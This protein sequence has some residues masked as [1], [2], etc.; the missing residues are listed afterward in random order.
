MAGYTFAMFLRFSTQLMV[1]EAFF[2]AGL[3]RRRWFPARL[4]AAL[5]TY[6]VAG[7]LLF[8]ALLNV[9]YRYWIVEIV[10]Y[11]VVFGATVALMCLLFRAPWRTVLFCATAAYAMQHI[12]YC[13]EHAIRSIWAWLFPSVAVP[14][15]LA[16]VLVMA[17][18]V[19]VGALMAATLMRDRGRRLQDGD[20]R[21]GLV[22]AAVLLVSV[23]LS[24]LLRHTSVADDMLLGV[25]CDLYAVVSCMLGFAMQ[26]GLW[27]RYR[28]ETDN[29]LLEQLLH[30]EYRLHTMSKRAIDAINMKS[31]DLKYR[32]NALR[33]QGAGGESLRHELDSL[34]SAV[35][36]Y[37]SVVSTGYDA[38]DLIVSEKTMICQHQG[39]AFTCV[40]DGA[41]LRFIDPP[42]VCS[43]LG[44]ALDNA[45]EHVMTEPPEHRII[46]L[47]VSRIG[48][49]VMVHVENDC[50]DS[51]VFRDG[52][53]VTTKNDDRY[54]G[55]GTRSIHYIA[56]RYGGEVA[57][58]VEDGK[59]ILDMLFAR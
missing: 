1:M 24:T 57:M 26:F 49:M 28:L 4:A 38:V 12:V 46:S 34:A 9:P 30:E 29:A 22:C 51:P 19:M 40:V 17:P 5:V 41:Q 52:L 54:H 16:E 10:Y 2:A 32:I 45:I 56:E 3:P 58:R 59:F 47:N 48:R 39:I 53:P 7:G 27:D 13:S 35:D 15:V 20:Y 25:I 11:V 14:T 44:N 50:T 6:Y 21:M 43:L 36:T 42:D 23:V 37:D 31:H 55:Y 18:F 8:A 33:Q